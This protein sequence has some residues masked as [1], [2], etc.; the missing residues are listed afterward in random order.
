MATQAWNKNATLA[1]IVAHLIT[2][3]GRK[4]FSPEL[5]TFKH[6]GGLLRWKV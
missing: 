4:G 1:K 2:E 3:L 6:G 5:K